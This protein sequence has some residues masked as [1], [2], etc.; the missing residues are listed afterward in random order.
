MK[1]HKFEYKGNENDRNI[2][3]VKCIKT[4]GE[5]CTTAWDKGFQRNI[6]LCCKEEI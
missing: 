1:N 3:L 2:Y 6:C 5:F 4:K